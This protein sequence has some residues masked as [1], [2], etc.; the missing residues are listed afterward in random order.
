MFAVVSEGP[1]VKNFSKIHA[2]LEE[3]M[4][5]AERLCKKDRIPFTVIKLVSTVIPEEV[6]VTW[7]KY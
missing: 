5:E 7:K 6:L 3:A 2:T 4:S 1:I